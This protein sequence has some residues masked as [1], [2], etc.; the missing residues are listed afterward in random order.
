MP[1]MKLNDYSMENL[2]AGL[3]RFYE[4]PAPVPPRCPRAKRD[5]LIFQ[6]NVK[7][8]SNEELFLLC[9][10][11]ELDG[12]PN[13]DLFGHEITARDFTYTD[14]T[15][16]LKSKGLHSIANTLTEAES[17]PDVVKKQGAVA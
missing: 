8:L 12:S 13:I 4:T 9:Y 2:T 17:C 11:E 14:Y 16:F 6:H 10:M 15:A 7:K 3:R 5:W 1:V